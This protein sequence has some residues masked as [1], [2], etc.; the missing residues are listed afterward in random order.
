MNLRRIAIPLAAAATLLGLAGIGAGVSQAAH[1]P[2]L[3]CGSV[4]TIN[5]TL[6]ADIGPC[7]GDGLIVRASGITL[8]LNG[9]RILGEGDLAVPSTCASNPAAPGC[10]R[11]YAGVRLDGVSFVNVVNQSQTRVPAVIEK[12]SAG[13]AIDRGSRNTVRGLTLRMNRTYNSVSQFGDGVLVISSTNNLIQGNTISDNGPFSG[14]STIA[15]SNLRT[16][17][18][19][20]A[21]PWY[22]TIDGNRVFTT[23]APTFAQMG[24]RLEGPGSSYSTVSNNDVSGYNPEGIAVLSSQNTDVSGED[25]G[26]PNCLLNP[27]NPV[28]TNNVVRGNTTYG[29]VA[30]IRAFVMGE[31]QTISPQR[32]TYENNVSNNNTAFGIDIPALTRNNTIRNNTALNNPTLRNPANPPCTAGNSSCNLRDTNRT[33]NAL[34]F[35]LPSNP[36]NCGSGSNVWTNNTHNI[37]GGSIGAVAGAF[38]NNVTTHGSACADNGPHGTASPSSPSPAAAAPADAPVETAANTLFRGRPRP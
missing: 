8:N 5:T 18:V 24:I 23:I 20:G 4:I 14:I 15:A 29:N 31:P 34:P 25:C 36:Y 1:A 17:R 27:P 22:N 28:N 21:L 30:G 26:T 10:A 12:F 9:K 16:N 2:V 32:T 11:D 7:D 35:A 37:V 3:N 33:N 6:Q 38:P 13:V 19:T